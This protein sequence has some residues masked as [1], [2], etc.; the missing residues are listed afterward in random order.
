[1]DLLSYP[2]QCKM[3]REKFNNSQ[4]FEYHLKTHGIIKT[5][6]CVKCA[7]V[8]LK[9]QLI[10][11]HL[12]K[13]VDEVAIKFCDDAG[14]CCDP[15]LAKKSP[16]LLSVCLRCK[17]VFPDRNL[18]IQHLKTHHK[19][20]SDEVYLS[21]RTIPSS[22]VPNYQEIS[23]GIPKNACICMIC[24]K[25]FVNKYTC[26]TH[27][28]TYHNGKI[29]CRSLDHETWYKGISE[30]EEFAAQEKVNSICKKEN[31]NQYSCSLCG[32]I[33][34]CR[35]SC[36]RHLQKQH[37][38][39]DKNFCEKLS[40]LCR[41]LETN[42]SPTSVIPLK[43]PTRT[44]CL[45]CNKVFHKKYNCFKHL[46]RKHQEDVKSSKESSNLFVEF[47]I[48][49]IEDIQED[50]PIDNDSAKISETYQCH[51]CAKVLKSSATLNIHLNNHKNPPK[52]SCSI[53]KKSFRCKKS[54]KQHM[55]S[56]H[57][58]NPQFICSVCKKI[59]TTSHTLKQHQLIH[60]GQKPFGCDICSKFFRL[61]STLEY[62]MKIHSGKLPF[63]CSYCQK[64][65]KVRKDCK[66]H[67][68]I[69]TAERPF[70]CRYQCGKDFGHSSAR[71]KHEKSH[72]RSSI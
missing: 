43:I 50:K 54:L 23:S 37:K 9:L 45:L 24:K 14:K 11:N 51:I 49:N 70:T 53:C 35:S 66:N 2:F 40:I 47:N 29:N 64:C 61:K 19:V 67:E 10:N 30:D 17:N 44:L 36:L 56:I 58:I 57:Q 33:L 39:H 52:F 25:V 68:R 31:G 38:I 46:L 15:K 12:E 27:I 16:N 4:E 69:H 13:H 42:S 8:F 22:C 7:E 26:I 72:E 21:I 60:T 62:H 48:R 32:K 41:K 65:F 6:T 3:C 28:N 71:Y 34:S 5:Y 20:S 1:M 55:N 59:F 18:L 63:Q